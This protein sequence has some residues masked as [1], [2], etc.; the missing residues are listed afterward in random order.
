MARTAAQVQADIDA[1]N[2]AIG[3]PILKVRYSDREITYRSQ[4]ELEAA[5][6]RLQKELGALNRTVPTRQYRVYS[7]KGW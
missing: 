3:N 1:T 6:S 7:E 4:P 2:A 5:L